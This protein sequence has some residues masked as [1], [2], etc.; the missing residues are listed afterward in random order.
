[1]KSSFQKNSFP[2]ELPAVLAPDVFAREGLEVGRGHEED[3]SA[4]DTGELGQ[5]PEVEHA[6]GVEAVALQAFTC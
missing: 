6:G 5:E 2:G 3:L 4:V 1:M